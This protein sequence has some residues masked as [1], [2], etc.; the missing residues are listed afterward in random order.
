PS[1]DL[2][3]DDLS[4]ISQKITP[5]RYPYKFEIIEEREYLMPVE[6]NTGKVWI[7]SKNGY[8]LREAQFMR[9]PCYV[10]QMTKLDKNYVYSK[11]VLYIDKETFRSVFLYIDKE[12][13]RSVFSANYDQEGRL[14]RTQIYLT[15]FMPDTGQIASY[16]SHILQFDHL[17]LHSSFQMPIPFPASF[18]RRDFTIEYL[19][20]RGK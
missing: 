14:Y 13:F 8:A 11:R 2:T 7:D 4:L 15:A 9:R 20:N 3:Y 5:E 12:T 6:Y 18:A 17:D 16:G 10:L 19:I 1:G